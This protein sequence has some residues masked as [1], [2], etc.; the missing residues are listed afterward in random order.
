[1]KHLIIGG[2]RSGKSAYAEQC[3]LQ[4][5][6]QPYYVAT[7]E[8]G[9]EEMAARIARH[10]AGRDAR[11]VLVEEPTRLAACLEPIDRR[12]HV[13]VV[14][15]LTLWLS[16]C[17]HQDCLDVEKPKLL[18]TLSKLQADIVL[19][20][21]EVGSGVIPMGELSRQ[22]VDHSGWLQ[23]DVARL[24]TDVTTVIAGLPLKLKESESP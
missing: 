10:R 18:E 9:D 20:C 2:A 22:F 23:Q 19:V 24:C 21:N 4:S 1:M 7:A 16:N 6:K 3:A 17:L 13:I 5:D 15:C 8:A 11:W 14:D 12:D